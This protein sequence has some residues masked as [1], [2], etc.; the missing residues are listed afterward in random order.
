MTW[1]RYALSECLLGV[2]IPS[3]TSVQTHV[4]Q[5]WLKAFHFSADIHAPQRINPAELSLT[6]SRTLVRLIFFGLQVKSHD[7]Y[8]LYCIK[9]DWWRHSPWCSPSARI[10][11]LQLDGKHGLWGQVSFKSLYLTA[12][13]A[14]QGPFVRCLHEN[15]FR[16]YGSM[17]RGNSSSRPLVRQRVCSM[18][19]RGEASVFKQA[20]RMTCS[21]T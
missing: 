3:T 1:Q 16:E 4:L 12:V 18:H 8:W 17:Y 20:E 5:K 6:C 19:L 2:Y 7:R 13:C 9:L 14:V 21:A 10:R 11:S 15:L